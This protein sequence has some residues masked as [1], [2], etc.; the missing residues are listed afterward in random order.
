MEPGWIA[1]DRRSAPART[2]SGSSAGH[3]AGIC[4]LLI[5]LACALSASPA[6]AASPLHARL[7]RRAGALLARRAHSHGALAAERRALAA[8]LATSSNDLT[9]PT[10]PRAL[11]VAGTGTIEGTVTSSDAKAPLGE[12]EVCAFEAEVSFEGGEEEEALPYEECATTDASGAY[13]LEVPAGE[14]DVAFYPLPESGLNYQPQFYNAKSR[15]SEANAV[16]VLAG[17]AT[18]GIDAALLPGA[19]ISGRVTSAL[20]KGPVAEVLVCAID[21]AVEAG[22]CAMDRASGEY[23]IPGLPDGSYVVA[24]FPL[25]EEAGISY[26]LQFY[27]GKTREIEAN[28]VSATVGATTANVD[29]ALVQDVPRARSRPGIAG[30]AAVGQTLTAVHAP[31]TNNP[32]SIVDVWGRCNATGESCF[33]AGTGPS[34]TVG[35]RDVG[36]TLIVKET[37]FDSAGESFPAFSEP[38][39]VVP[40]PSEP[41][42]SPAAPTPPSAQGVLA[43]STATA[44]IA[45][46]RSLLARL[47]TPGGRGAKIGRLLENGGY[48]A[49][50]TSL[51]AGRL[52]ISWYLVPKGAHLA[53]AKP[54]LVASGSSSPTAP[55]PAKLKIK[56]TRKGRGMLAHARRLALTAKGTLKPSSGTALSAK[57]SFTVK[58]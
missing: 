26:A 33:V 42:G 8:G 4:A 55:G 28:R 34:Y 40:A 14:Y 22:S 3:I 11:I 52:T 48:S 15:F 37:A 30:T 53:S 35:S 50:F 38:T 16:N 43:S 31:W 1:V 54:V 5:L 51:T 36:H 39:S 32:T 41:G 2:F 56:L 6:A 44:S 12:V 19:E 7:A 47:L 58:R 17:Q 20:T 23:T 27:S 18:S 45:Q 9:I 29:A 25:G 24:F 46:L 21:E 13:T 10:S 57:R 49:S